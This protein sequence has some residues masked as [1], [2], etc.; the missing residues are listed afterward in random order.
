MNRT[1][2]DCIYLHCITIILNQLST[3]KIRYKYLSS[4]IIKADWTSWKPIQNL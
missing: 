4:I 1:L 3:A 2:T